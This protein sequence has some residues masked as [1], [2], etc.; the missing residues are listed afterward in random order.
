MELALIQKSLIAYLKQQ[1]LW[2]GVD[3]GTLTLIGRGWE[4]DI[5]AL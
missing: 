1:A 3:Y 2:P 5:Y 4:S